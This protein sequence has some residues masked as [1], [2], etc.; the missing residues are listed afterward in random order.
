MA[1]PLS[2]GAGRG[3]GR[4]GRAETNMVVFRIGA[5]RGLDAGEV[6][7]WRRDGSASAKLMCKAVMA[8]YTHD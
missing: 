4:G 5:R 6:L 1:A 3:G 8:H 7:L 2:C